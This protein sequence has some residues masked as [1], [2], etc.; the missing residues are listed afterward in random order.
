MP[1]EWGAACE[2]HGC[3]ACESAQEQQLS[4][5]TTAHAL[6]NFQIGI[7]RQRKQPRAGAPEPSQLVIMSEYVRTAGVLE[8]H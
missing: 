3:A 7:E 5:H 6:G 4:Q 8:N 2:L 1:L